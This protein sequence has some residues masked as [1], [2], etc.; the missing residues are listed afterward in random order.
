[1]RRGRGEME[2]K[3]GVHDAV[4]IN[5]R[6]LVVIISVIGQIQT[7]NKSSGPTRRRYREQR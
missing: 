7:T 3:K 5:N 4:F 6:V 1:V 2:G